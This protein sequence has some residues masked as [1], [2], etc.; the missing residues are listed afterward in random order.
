MLLHNFPFQIEDMMWKTEPAVNLTRAG[1]RMLW[2]HT[3]QVMHSDILR[4][5]KIV[6][7]IIEVFFVCS[8]I[9]YIENKKIVRKIK[10]KMFN[11]REANIGR[12]K[13][14]RSEV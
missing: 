11:I 10:K 5:L 6:Y 8:I 4:K 7:L 14:S 13:D 12:K 1:Q 3:P 9:Q 2:C